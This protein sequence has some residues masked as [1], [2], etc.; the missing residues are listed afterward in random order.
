MG[1]DA[2]YQGVRR[3]QEGE[4][5]RRRRAFE[6]LGEGQQ[7]EL[8]LVTCSDSRIDPALLTQT[9]QRNL[10]AARGPFPTNAD[11]LAPIPADSRGTD[12]T[13]LNR[14]LPAPMP[15]PA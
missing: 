4:F 8:L 1:L 2:I 11:S 7:P 5:P 12:R 6:A 3:F 14:S 13:R 15:G 10:P 9:E